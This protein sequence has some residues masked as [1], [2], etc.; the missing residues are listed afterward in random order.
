MTFPRKKR[1]VLKKVNLVAYYDEDLKYLS[2]EVFVEKN[3][4]AG[5]ITRRT[6]HFHLPPQEL[7]SLNHGDMGSKSPQNN[8]QIMF[9]LVPKAKV[10][11]CLVFSQC[12]ISR[13]YNL[14]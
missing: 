3:N 9:P 11:L 4:F 10:K 5:I 12:P 2:S 8:L 1:I 7:E 13:K 6:C 14:R